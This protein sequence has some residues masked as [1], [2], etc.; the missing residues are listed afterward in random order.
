MLWPNI[1]VTQ[2]HV[3]VHP[4]VSRYALLT[5]REFVHQRADVFNDVLFVKA[6]SKSTFTM[7]TTTFCPHELDPD[8]ITIIHT[9]LPS[10]TLMSSITLL[11][12]A[13]PEGVPDVSD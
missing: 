6:L 1:V 13:E 8:L 12:E 10:L 7:V 3:C 4:Y 2:Y 9:R 11:Y 5:R